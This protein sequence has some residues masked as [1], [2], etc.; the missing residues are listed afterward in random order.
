MNNSKQ[1]LAIVLL[2]VGTL[3]LSLIIINNYRTGSP[4]NISAANNYQSKSL[5]DIELLE[6][7][8]FNA[9]TPRFKLNVQTHANFNSVPQKLYLIDK[10]TNKSRLELKLNPSQYV[11]ECMK[12]SEMMDEMKKWDTDWFTI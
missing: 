8:D 10:S 7:Q 3:G 11:E 2:L 5:A 4:D 12:H 9:S 1:I 6:T